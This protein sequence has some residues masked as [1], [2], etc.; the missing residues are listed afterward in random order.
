[1]ATALHCSQLC[2]KHQRHC[3]KSSCPALVNTLSLVGAVLVVSTVSCDQPSSSSPCWE[4]FRSNR[5]KKL[6]PAT[7]WHLSWMLL[8]S[9]SHIDRP[10]SLFTLVCLFSALRTTGFVTAVA[11]TFFILKSWKWFF[12]LCHFSI[13]CILAFFKSIVNPYIMVSVVFLKIKLSKRNCDFHINCIS[14]SGPLFQYHT[15]LF[16]LFLLCFSREHSHPRWTKRCLLASGHNH[17]AC[18]TWT[19]ALIRQ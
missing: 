16:L 2:S 12:M 17:G 3:K 11:F 19:S 7:V 14:S 15:S 5:V 8:N 9:H 4:P 18:V 10:V 1:M 13:S 6:E